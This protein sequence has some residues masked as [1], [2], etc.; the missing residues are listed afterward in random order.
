MGILNF[1]ILYFDL[2][3]NCTTSFSKLM[4]VNFYS[5]ELSSQNFMRI[6]QICVG[7][8]TILPHW[9]IFGMW[10]EFVRVVLMVGLRVDFLVLF[11]F[12]LSF[13]FPVSL[14]LQIRDLGIFGGV[15]TICCGLYIAISHDALEIEDLWGKRLDFVNMMELWKGAFV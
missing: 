12:C 3:M 15:W 7:N 8:W 11:A 6:F 13:I 4:W 10:S 9:K 2:Y 1:W 5:Y 14:F